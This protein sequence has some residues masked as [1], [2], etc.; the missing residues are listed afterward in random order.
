MQQFLNH[1][2]VMI[3]ACQKV[4]VRLRRDF[5]EIENLQNTATGARSF[6][7]TARV[8]T[9]E[10]LAQLLQTA[11]PKYSLFIDG[12]KVV[13]GTD[14]GHHFSVQLF[15]GFDSFL[16]GLSGFRLLLTMHEQKDAIVAL[17]YDPLTDECFVAEKNMGAFLYGPYKSQRLRVSER[18]K[19]FFL[20]SNFNRDQRIAHL[21]DCVGKLIADFAS[22]KYDC[23][24]LKGLREVEETV[25]VLMAKEAKGLVNFEQGTLLLSSQAA[26]HALD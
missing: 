6:V 23:I 13:Q 24:H 22:G 7:E 17:I 18:K 21:S 9:K 12:E 25:A 11:R 26:P 16:H 19:E 5:G 20:A 2:R 15:S 3:E 4:S 10:T 8:R 14:I 1:T